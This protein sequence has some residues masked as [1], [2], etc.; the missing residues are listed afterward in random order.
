MEMGL[1][2]GLG[3]G[4]TGENPLTDPQTF[5]HS[6][7]IYGAMRGAGAGRAVVNER[8]AQ[9]VARLLASR[10]TAAVRRGMQLVSRSSNLFGAIQNADAALGSIGARSLQALSPGGGASNRQYREAEKFEN[11]WP[12]P[13]Q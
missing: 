11:K 4:L 12:V 7:L 9:Q 5:L 10:D 6:A 8:V 1:A 3:G 13:R 2:G